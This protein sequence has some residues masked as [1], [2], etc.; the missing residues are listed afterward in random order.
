MCIFSQPVVSVTDT[1]IFARLLADGQQYLVYQM[2]FETNKSNAMILPLPVQLPVSEKESLQFISLKD[3]P[4]FFEDLEKGFPVVLPDGPA[5][6]RGDNS[7]TGLHKPKLQVHEVGEFIASFVPS[8]PDFARLDEQFRI[9]RESWDKMPRYSDFG[10]AVFQLKSLKGKP[11]PMAFKF[12]SRL[13][14][15]GGGSIFFPTVHIHDGQVHAQEKFDHTLYLQASQFDDA[16]GEYKK[17]GYLVTDEATGYVRSKWPAGKF[18]DI[19]AS[20]GILAADALVHRLEMR[21]HRDNVDILASLNLS[22]RDRHSLRF[23]FG[24]STAVVGLAGIVGLKW[25][26][27]RRDIISECRNDG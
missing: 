15:R 26:F 25:L 7:A 17:R 12:H 22:R 10:F 24:L 1:K 11:H 21:G 4:H 2:R 8:I 14:T 13:K 27:H 16:C 20:R 3:Y 9:P 19:K 18:C 23:P 6:S 5:R